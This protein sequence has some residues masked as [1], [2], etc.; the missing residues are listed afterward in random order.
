LTVLSSSGCTPFINDRPGGAIVLCRVNQTMDGAASSGGHLVGRLRRARGGTRPCKGRFEG[1]AAR[2]WAGKAVRTAADPARAYLEG[3]GAACGAER[4]G[5]PGAGHGASAYPHLGQA[6]AA[7]PAESTVGQAAPE[8]T[9]TLGKKRSGAA[10]VRTGEAGGKNGGFEGR[11][12]EN[13]TDARPQG[14]RGCARGKHS[15]PVPSNGRAASPRRHQGCH[16][17]G[18]VCRLLPVGVTRDTRWWLHD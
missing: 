7:R 13:V 16:G 14:V 10:A 1:R 11:R 4:P 12:D 5:S 18:E 15:C 3:W 17:S 8:D 6:A 2:D 9:V